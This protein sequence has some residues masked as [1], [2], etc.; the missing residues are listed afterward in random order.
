MRKLSN[1]IKNLIKP[2]VKLVFPRFCGQ[3]LMVTS[4]IRLTLKFIK[5]Y[6]NF[7]GSLGN[8]LHEVK[9]NQIC[10]RIYESEPNSQ[11]GGGE[12]FQQDIWALTKVCSYLPDKHIDIGSRID[13]FSAQCSA[14]VPVEFLDCRYVDYKLPN[15]NVV[16]GDLLNLPYQSGSVCSISCLHTLEHVGL[17]RYGDPIDVLG[18]EKGILELIR[19]LGAG[20]NL[21][22]SFPISPKSFIEFNAH[23]ITNPKDI[24]NLHMRNLELVEFSVVKGNTLYKSIEF[25]DFINMDI[26]ALGL[27][28][29]RGIA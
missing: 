20:G 12:Y 13:G 22:I 7:T 1:V 29:L 9:F 17:G 4:H 23:R 25:D 10:P 5:D 21:Y 16:E 11:S 14:M 15:M 3:K 2:Y 27:F 18:M 26:I 28:H 19:V 8:S 24:Y 6:L